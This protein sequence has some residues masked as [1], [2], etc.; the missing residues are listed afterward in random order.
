LAP[1]SFVP[2]IAQPW[3]TGSRSSPG[4]ERQASADE[5]APRIHPHFLSGLCDPA[6]P[7]TS[8]QQRRRRAQGA[9]ARAGARVALIQRVKAAGAKGWM[10]KPFNPEL[11][12]AAQAPSRIHASSFVTSESAP[13]ADLGHKLSFDGRLSASGL[14]RRSPT[15]PSCRDLPRRSEP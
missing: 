9:A 15:R 6:R 4:A 14:P 10:M 11:P 8:A 2:W 13:L 5:G 12:T 7:W 3:G 1:S